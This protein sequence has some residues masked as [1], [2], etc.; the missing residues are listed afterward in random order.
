[1]AHPIPDLNHDLDGHDP[2][3]NSVP[4]YRPD[5]RIK[6]LGKPPGGHRPNPWNKKMT[7]AGLLILGY[8]IIAN[9]IFGAPPSVN[10]PYSTFLGELNHNVV[11]SVNANGNFITGEF[12][13]AIMIPGDGQ[14]AYRNFTTQVPVF[15]GGEL[16]TLLAKH[17]V[18]INATSTAY[19]FWEE[20]LLTFGPLVL[21]GGIIYYFMR[22]SP[23]GAGGLLGIG[24]S[25]AKLYDPETTKITFKDVAGIEDA[26]GELE[27]IVDFLK[28][29]GKYSRLGGR[30]P[31][32]V[33][34]VGM[35]GT[36]K[37]LLAKAVA[38]EAN[39]PFFS[40]SASE[41]I[42][43]I[44]GVGASRVRALFDEARKASP[45]IIFIDELDAIGRSR[46][47]SSRF[48]GHDEREQTLNQ[49]LT[50]MDG[51][52]PREGVIVLAATNRADVLDSALM[53]PGRFDR[54]VMVQA[55]DRVGREAILHIHTRG[56]PLGSDV[57]LGVLAS[58]TIGLVG[59]DLSNLVNEAAL[60][61]AKRGHSTVN[62]ADFQ[63]SIEK[64]LLGAKRQIVLSEDDRWRI[65]YHE[66]GHALLGLLLPEAD[67]VRRVSIIP[68]GMALGVTV[69]SPIDDRHNYMESYL[70]ARMIGALGGRAA[71][72]LVYEQVTTGAENDLKQVMNIARQMV[73]SWGM[74]PK[75]GPL[76]LEDDNDS[77]F[78]I[79]KSAYSEKTAQIID[80]EIKAIVDDCFT[81]AYDILRANK[82]KLIKLSQ[83]L[84]E[85]ESLD[86]AAILQ[87]TG[88][89]AKTSVPANMLPD[90]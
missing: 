86:E 90:A 82:D 53:R 87:V 68:R 3:L 7:W 81:K 45:A 60:L 46:G 27:E 30:T 20:L 38:G 6:V 31:K 89:A 83:A 54:R 11:Y 44:V 18:I 51:F 69:Q 8:L 34:L 28:N 19:P 14:V 50:E 77:E 52:D 71:E 65:A 59:A 61:A 63:D 12:K 57:D 78:G 72:K 84:M 17:R 10:L 85:N 2:E 37:T 4:T 75:L 80:A 35:P 15:G 29:P 33:L 67:P 32:G 47:S 70:R 36:G 79:G 49:I 66:S 23:G 39:V 74:S 9:I 21:I 64:V 43:M 55:P 62:R 22:R 56:V 40:I 48:G 24:K 58:Q 16:E 76:H 5:K 1:M 42:E 25:Q 13:K 88:L 26:K 73:V 41:F